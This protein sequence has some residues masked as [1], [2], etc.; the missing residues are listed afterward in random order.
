MSTKSF[1]TTTSN[2]TINKSRSHLESRYPEL[3]ELDAKLK[4]ISEKV[5]PA[6]PYILTVPSNRPFNLSAHQAD[7]LRRG[8]PFKAQEAQLQ[9]LS[10]LADW[11]NGLITPVGGWDN[12]KGEIMEQASV[13]RSTTT[14]PK[15][16]AKKIS[17]SDY[18]KRTTGQLGTNGHTKANSS[19]KPGDV[20]SAPSIKHSP[21]I[22]AGQKR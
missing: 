17:M 20:S 3:R 5:I 21:N 13:A 22:Q 16:G 12:E 7:D 2:H 8:T 9:Y 6:S 19:T 11:D 4:N 10:F 18:K 15:V 14:T 1:D